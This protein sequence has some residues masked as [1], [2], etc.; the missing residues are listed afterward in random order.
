M[1][2]TQLASI[3][4]HELKRLCNVPGVLRCMIGT[5][6][7]PSGSFTSN[8]GP[9]DLQVESLRAVVRIHYTHRARVP[10]HN[11]TR[12]TVAGDAMFVETIGPVVVAAAFPAGGAHIKSA[13]RHMRAVAKRMAKAVA[14]G[15]AEPR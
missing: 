5:E 2:N 13:R 10:N 7:A 15:R 3:C 14:K 1:N 12:A 4:D 9:M 8:G 6:D 11:F